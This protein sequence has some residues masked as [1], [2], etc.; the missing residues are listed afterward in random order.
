MALSKADVERR[1]SRLLGGVFVVLTGF[2]GLAVVLSFLGPDLVAPLHKTPTAARLGLLLLT[3]GF[4]ALVW[5]RESTLRRMSSRIERKDGLL[6]AFENRLRAVE[7]LLEAGDRLRAPLAVEDVLRVIAGAAVDLVG[8][9]SGTAE[10]TEDEAGNLV[11]VQSHSS[12]GPDADGSGVSLR[13]PLTSG[14]E[15]IGTLT[16]AMP[17]RRE[18]VDAGTL[19]VLERFAHDAGA[20]LGKARIMS[21]HKASL[22]HMQAANLVKSRFLATVSHELRTPLTSILG[23]SATLDH[24][25]EKLPDDHRREF[26]GIIEEQANRLSRLVERVLE[27]ARLELEGLTIQPVLHDVR[28]SVRGALKA[29]RASEPKRVTIDMPDVP[30]AGEVDPFVVHQIVLNLL[31]N[32]LRFTRGEVELSARGTG[33]AIEISVV[34]RGPGMDAARLE[35]VL[36]PHLRLKDDFVGGAGLGLHIVKTLVQ[37]HGGTFAL[38]TGE[39]GTSAQVRLPRTSGESLMEAVETVP[40]WEASK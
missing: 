32:A 38:R 33:E 12:R 4:I 29:F 2:A 14:E 37:D 7:S 21:G 35:R 11:V 10:L 19:E 5:E 30:V 40:A 18:G 9:L 8:A 28:D 25:W 1:R 15:V 26:L 17:R 3:V 16:L 22:A 39:W 20:A 13:V 23:Y 6:A 27:A 24:H 36:E 31:D 34:D